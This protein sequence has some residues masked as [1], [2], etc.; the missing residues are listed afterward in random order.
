M[1][2]SFKS[3]SS[4]SEDATE[5]PPPPP[6]P[7]LC[8]ASSSAATSA[9]HHLRRLLFTAADFIS[10]SNVSAAQNILSILTSNSSPYGDST[11]RL[12]HLFTKALSVRIGLSENAAT[13]TT[14]EMTSST[15]FTSSVCK[16]QFLFRTKNNN[17]SDLE[18]CYYLWLNQLTPFIRFS[19]LTANQAILDATETNNGNGAYIYLT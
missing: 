1:L 11:E 9:A 15:V 19:H 2:A 10:Q 18:S 7:P 6:P 4:S 8:L 3:S 5:N 14:N 13:W 12:V 17:N 16:E